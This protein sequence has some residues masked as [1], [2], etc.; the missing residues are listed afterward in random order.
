MHFMN[1][2]S[3]ILGQIAVGLTLQQKG[4]VELILGVRKSGSDSPHFTFGPLE[5]QAVRATFL[6]PKEK[7]PKHEFSIH[8]S[9]SQGVWER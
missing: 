8:H 4:T 3:N 9:G 5:L 6:L 1:R 7:K 2:N